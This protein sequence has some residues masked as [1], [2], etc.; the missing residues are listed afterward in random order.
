MGNR[1]MN[2]V[3][4]YHSCLNNRVRF[5]MLSMTLIAIFSSNNCHRVHWVCGCNPV[6]PIT[7]VNSLIWI[8]SEFCNEYHCWQFHSVIHVMTGSVYYM[9][10]PYAG[11]QLE[12]MFRLSPILEQQMCQRVYQSLDFSTLRATGLTARYLRG[13]HA[14]ARRRDFKV[15]VVRRTKF[16]RCLQYILL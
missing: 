12:H 4:E 5:T 14:S 9:S 2:S 3:Q 8:S 1:R 16:P 15:G 11:L 13:F 7:S 10:S 6:N